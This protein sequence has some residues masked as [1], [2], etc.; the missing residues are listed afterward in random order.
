M[1]SR[2]AIQNQIN[3][4]LLPQKGLEI[5][6]IIYYDAR[7]QQV[8]V[9]LSRPGIGDIKYS[10]LSLPTLSTGTRL[11]PPRVGDTVLLGFPENTEILPIIITINYGNLL[12]SPSLKDLAK[13]AVHRL[14]RLIF[15]RYTR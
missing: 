8:D 3:Q 13:P 7:L 6:K 10:G 2:S 5:G 1:N 9:Y 11:G 12:Q 14:G 15:E 4:V